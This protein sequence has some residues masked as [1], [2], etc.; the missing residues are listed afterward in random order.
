MGTNWGNGH[1]ARAVWIKEVL[2]NEVGSETIWT[3]ENLPVS[4][5]ENYLISLLLGM[6]SPNYNIFACDLKYNIEMP[7]VSYMLS[8][9]CFIL[10]CIIFNCCFYQCFFCF[11]LL[12]TIGKVLFSPPTPHPPFSLVIFKKKKLHSL[13]N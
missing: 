9:L 6:Q 5:L 1:H 3:F 13:I 11:Y 2:L 8:Q 12:I 4:Q 10:C 7:G